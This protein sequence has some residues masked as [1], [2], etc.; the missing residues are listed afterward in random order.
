MDSIRDL[1]DW[2]REVDRLG[3]LKRVGA[4]VDWDLEM[5]AVAYMGSKRLGAPALLFENIKGYP[6]D[7]RA[8]FNVLGSSLDRIALAMR[9]PTGK[10]ALE[11]IQL[12][13]ERH[14]IRIPPKIVE[15]ESAPINENILQGDDIDLYSFP[16]PKMWPLDGGRYIGTGCV[17]ITKDPEAGWLNLGTYRQ[18]IQSRNEAGFYI[19]PGKDGLLHREGWW[20]MG[21]PCEVAVAYGVD[22]L[23]FIVGSTGFAKN[24]SEYDHAGGIQGRPVEVVKGKVTDLLIPARAEI[25]I[26]GLAYPDKLKD[27]GPFGEFS[28]YYGRP[29]GPSPVIDVKCV[30]YRNDPI[31]T[32]ALMAD[33]PSCEQSYFISIT[34]SAKIWDD[35]SSHMGIPGIRGVYCVPAAIGGFGMIVVSM[36]QRYAGHAQ[37][38]AALAAQCAGGAYITKWTVVV[39]ED[40]DPTDLEQVVWAMASRCNPIDDIDVLRNTWST[41]LDPAQVPAEKRPYGSKALVYACKDHRYLKSFS[42]RTQL[43]EETY[44]RVVGRWKEFGLPGEAPKITNFETDHIKKE[45]KK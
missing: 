44:K 1:R 11:L 31:L 22:P 2:L 21:K 23:L 38:V 30:H 16:A 40:V 32:C 27:E 4:E 34:R 24:V 9:Q 41:P 14:Q 43:A 5:G 29:Q 17:V 36:E 8:L 10:S 18:M 39:D 13:R 20:K 33:H 7:R 25:V 3:E 37:Q 45:G 26:E 42:K 28:G 12:V 15:S 6:K 19:S 35:L